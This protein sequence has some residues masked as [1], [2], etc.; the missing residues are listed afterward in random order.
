[1]DTKD[2]IHNFLTQFQIICETR[3]LNKNHLFTIASAILAVTFV[4]SGFLMDRFGRKKVIIIKTWVTVLFLIPL[5]IMGFVQVSKTV[6]VIAIFFGSFIFASYTFD[7]AILGFESLVKSK[8]DNFIILLMATK[9]ISIGFVCL[10]FYYLNNWAYFM[11][12]EASLMLLLSILFL[13]YTYESPYY[14]L[15]STG[16]TDEVKYIL[17]KIATVNDEDTVDDET[18]LFAYTQQQVKNRHSLKFRIVNMFNNQQ[19]LIVIGALSMCWFAYAAGQMIHIV[20]LEH[21]QSNEYLNVVLMGSTEFLCCLLSK[22]F[23]KYLSR[24]NALLYLYL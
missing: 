16:S 4:T 13:K 5:L 10:I 2:S 15:A 14:V 6:V 22:V 19:K 7:I 20:F 3:T 17:N 24:K 23:L 12:I 8:R 11:I 1:M 9:F 18:I 21:I